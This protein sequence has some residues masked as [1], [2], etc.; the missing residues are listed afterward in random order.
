MKLRV[1]LIPLLY[2]LIH[3]I[4]R[5]QRKSYKSHLMSSRTVGTWKAVWSCEVKSVM[6]FLDVNWKNLKSSKTVVLVPISDPPIVQLGLGRSIQPDD[7]KERDDVYFECDVKANPPI[8]GI[9]WQHNVSS[10]LI[11]CGFWFKFSHS[12]SPFSS[13]H[14]DICYLLEK[15]C[16]YHLLFFVVLVGVPLW[17]R[18]G[19][20][21]HLV[22]EFHIH[23]Q[24]HTKSGKLV[25]II[26]KRFALSLILIGPER[27]ELLPFIYFV[28][29]ISR[30]ILLKKKKETKLQNAPEHDESP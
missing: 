12:L 10:Y 9:E 6:V 17:G 30:P 21:T 8:Q 25:N 19:H 27:K 26:F 13:S 18:H 24:C 23:S 2:F 5:E 28:S 7:I 29:W 20:V 22:L 1:W 14:K 11:H 4:V 15:S 16:F 3:P